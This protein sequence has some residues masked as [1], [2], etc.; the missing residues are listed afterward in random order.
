MITATSARRGPVRALVVVTYLAMITVNVLA[1]ALPL[2]GRST[3]EVS[4][5]Y[6]NLFTPAG[7]TFS[8]W[9]VIYLLL[10]LHVLFQL[11]L[12]RGSQPGGERSAL[13]NRVGLLFAISSAANTGW[14]FAWHYEMMPLSVLLIAVILVCLIL[15]TNSLRAAQLS[16]RE[17]WFVAVPFSVYFGWTT[18]ATVANVTVL[19]VSRSWDGFGLAESVWAAIVVVV[20]TVIGTVTTLRN[21]DFGYGLVLIWAYCGILIRHTSASGLDGRYPVVVAVVVV[22]LLVFVIAEVVVVSRRK[23]AIS[24]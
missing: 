2:N 6:P 15:I 5:A 17:R 9:G 10:G 7:L 3:G 11:G 13:M 23:S 18:V 16:A 20:A 12:F 1:N 24:R 22:S 21:Q 4:E 8:I 19:L 14:I